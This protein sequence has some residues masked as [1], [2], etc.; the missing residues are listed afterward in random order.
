MSSLPNFLLSP[1]VNHCSMHALPYTGVMFLIGT[2][3][4][5]GVELHTTTDNHLHEST[6]QWISINGEVLFLGT[7]SVL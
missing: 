7:F 6:K 4:G 5:I 2:L 1:V 3:M